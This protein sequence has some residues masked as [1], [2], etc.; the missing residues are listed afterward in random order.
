MKGGAS[1]R[2]TMTKTVKATIGALRRLE[3]RRSNERARLRNIEGDR[4]VACLRSD[5]P[6]GMQ[7][8]FAEEE[9]R[10][11]HGTSPALPA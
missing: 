11:T 8:V 5:G 6:F 1:W 10:K 9:C 2:R 7:G 3:A 4:P